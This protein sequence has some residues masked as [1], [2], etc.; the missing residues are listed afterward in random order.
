M[1]GDKYQTS[2]Q[3]FGTISDNDWKVQVLIQ[4][5]AK[6]YQPKWRDTPFHFLFGIL[7]E[8]GS[9]HQAEL[10]VQI[11]FGRKCTYKNVDKN[12]LNLF[13]GQNPKSKC[14]SMLENITVIWILNI[15]VNF[16]P[17]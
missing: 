10:G 13:H 2:F 4:M 14:L 16:L 11:T 3:K 6:L 9:Y 7:Q 8:Q 17:L 1:D 5:Y 15:I 12:E